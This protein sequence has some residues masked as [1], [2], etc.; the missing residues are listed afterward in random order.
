MHATKKNYMQKI[1]TQ[2][3]F[4]AKRYALTPKSIDTLFIGGGTPSCV[5]AELYDDF[6]DL[7]APY[8]AENAEITT[9]AN[10]NSASLEWLQKMQHFG[11]NRISFGVQSFDEYKLKYLGRAH[12]SSEAI[13]AI[14]NAKK[15]GFKHISLDLIYGVK[16]DTKTLLQKDI[17]YAFELG[18]DHISA[19]ELTIEEKTKFDS[20]DK[21]ED[22]SLGIFIANEITKRG[23]MHYEVSNYGKYKCRHN[24]GYW[25]LKEYIGIGAGAV[26]MHKKSRIYTTNNITTY[27]NNPLLVSIEH[28]SD[29]D[30]Q[31]EK[32][33]LGLRSEI[34]IDE[35]ILDKKML[36][37]AKI[38]VEENKLIYKN[39]YFYNRDY[40]LSDAIVL[41]LI[42]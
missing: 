33:F 3:I 20:S 29:T 9:E 25:H 22:D 26:G 39:K 38:L 35:K 4:E 17:E 27:I 21:K 23:F 24:L 1:C 30:I 14:Q 2:F 19:Y 31:T 28:L 12:D 11:V 41:Y 7:I 36:Q 8:L 5:A 10:P 13:L 34:G 6:F 37:R 40:F 32:I 18:C 42:D 16:N 15:S